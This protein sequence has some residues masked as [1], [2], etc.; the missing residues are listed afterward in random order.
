MP[1]IPIYLS[2]IISEKLQLLFRTFPIVV[3]SG[4]R[5]VGKSTLLAHLFSDLPRV[6]FDPVTDIEN[7]RR[8][9]ELFLR[10]RPPPL[11]LD[12]I[13]FAPELVPVIKRLL[14]ADRRPGQYLVTGSQQW[15]IMKMLAESLTGRAVFLDLDGFGI[16][17][18]AH[19]P[20]ANAWLLYWLDRAGKIMPEQIG[21]CALPCTLYEQLWRGF[22]P[23]AQFIPQSTVPDFHAAYL[24]TYIERDVRQVADVSDLVQFGHFFR[25]CA[26]LTAQEINHSQLGRELGVTPQTAARWVGVLHAMFQW[27]PIPAYSGNT[28]KRISGKP[29]GYL[30]DTGLVC[31][32]QAIA[33]PT[34]LGGHPLWGALFE[35]AVVAEIRKQCRLLPTAPNLYHWRSHGGAEVDILLEWN[36]C[37]YPI[38]IKGKSHPDIKDARGIQS[39]WQT[40]PRLPRMPGLVVAPSETCY[41]IAKDIWVMPWDAQYLLNTPSLPGSLTGRI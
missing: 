17:E 34:V 20:A 19:V 36:G 7:A 9:P 1:A 24:R 32:A 31:H 38:E 13:Q 30:A 25:L 4:A 10:N 18:I 15:G 35:T 2:R 41:Q 27:I 11:I 21:R 26:A 28:I 6:I 3:L 5:Q 33:A 37:L 22:L 23:E 12:E 8:D 14:E 16:A 39:F 29:K 40:Y